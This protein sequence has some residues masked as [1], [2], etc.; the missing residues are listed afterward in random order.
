M[1]GNINVTATFTQLPVTLTVLPASGG[2]VASTDGFINCPGMC[3]HTYNPNTPVTLNATPASGWNFSGWT[4]AC[5]GVGS[6]NITMTQNF[7]L[8]GVFVQPGAGVQLTPVTPCRAVDTRGS[9][10][11]QWP[12]PIARHPDASLSTPTVCEQFLG[13]LLM[14]F[15][16]QRR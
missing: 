16:Q 12:S 13:L 9:N 5:M 15:P 11:P 8:S 10:G 7:D 3:Q 2:T 6:C 4:G 14:D 1:T